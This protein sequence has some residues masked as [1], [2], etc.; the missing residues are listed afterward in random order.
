MLDYLKQ[1]KVFEDLDESVLKKI[2]SFSRLENHKGDE[3][4][5]REDSSDNHDLFLVL[6]G[7]V[8]IQVSSKFFAD[9][10]EENKTIYTVNQGD[11]FGEMSCIVNRRRS[12]S[13][14]TMGQS[15][16]IRVQG[17]KF[18]KF[19]ESDKEVGF[20]VL[21]KLYESLYERIENSNFMLRNFLI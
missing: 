7:R 10:K 15:D 9:D 3:V 5:I 4:I 18:N 20:T 12:A 16:I 2:A 14:I 1:F 19:M 13:A 8:R 17:D 21:K 11:I 6:K